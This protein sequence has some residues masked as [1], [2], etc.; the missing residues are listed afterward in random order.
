MKKIEVRDILE[1]SL[2]GERRQAS[3]GLERLLDLFMVG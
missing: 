3:L 2:S 1:G